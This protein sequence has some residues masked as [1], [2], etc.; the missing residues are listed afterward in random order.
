M[1]KDQKQ[2]Y[3][4]KPI[5]WQKQNPIKYHLEDIDDTKLPEGC[6]KIKLSKEELWKQKRTEHAK[7]IRKAHKLAT[8]HSLQEEQKMRDLISEAENREEPPPEPMSYSDPS[9]ATELI[10]CMQCSFQIQR[11][12][13]YFCIYCTKY[14]CYTCHNVARPRSRDVVCV[15]CDWLLEHNQMP[16]TF[17]QLGCRY[18]QQDKDERAVREKF[19][20]EIMGD[21]MLFECPL[22]YEHTY[23]K[24]IYQCEH[25]TRYV[26]EQCQ[27]HKRLQKGDTTTCTSCA[28]KGYDLI[29]DPDEDKI[30]YLREAIGH[31]IT[32]QYLQ[33]TPQQSVVIRDATGKETTIILHAKTPE[34]YYKQLCALTGLSDEEEESEKENESNEVQEFIEDEP[35][36]E[37]DPEQVFH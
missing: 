31:E 16:H 34:E 15:Y 21:D 11:Q 19:L 18:F 4:I 13:R 17:G 8:K 26:C 30:G 24:P 5:I 10:R 22:C 27:I 37:A 35:E 7:K 36:I 28:M 14:I 23:H 32:E 33:E 2:R 20:D 1:T 29:T 3:P 6:I 9:K 12:H 25:C